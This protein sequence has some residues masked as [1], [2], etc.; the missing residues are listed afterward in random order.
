MAGDCGI[1]IFCGKDAD[2]NVSEEGRELIAPGM[3]LAALA[4]EE[5]T[6]VLFTDRPVLSAPAFLQGNADRILLCCSPLFR[7]YNTEVYTDALC[8][9]CLKYRPS[10]L[11][12]PATEHGRDFAPRLAARLKTGLTADCT[13][14]GYDPDG[15]CVIWT[16]PTLGGNLMADI[17]CA[18]SRPQIGTVRPVTCHGPNPEGRKKTVLIR[19]HTELL[20]ASSAVRLLGVTGMENGAETWRKADIIVSGGRGLKKAEDFALL[21]KLAEA[22]GAEVGGSRAVTDLGWLP[23]NRQVGQTGATVS[24]SVYIACGISGS[25]QHFAG[26]SESSRIIA[27]NSDPEAPVFRTADLGIVGDLYGVLPRWIEA[28]QK[29]G[30]FFRMPDRP[31]ARCADSGDADD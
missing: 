9:L 31:V 18:G 25:L 16:R 14:V 13:S 21:Q 15:K 3:E 23:K 10:A 22:L 27:V 4:G 30:S 17:V 8:R 24:P 20:P 2:G 19:E 11:L 29:D 1:W 5:L 6:V 12:I 28:A 7:C 26:V